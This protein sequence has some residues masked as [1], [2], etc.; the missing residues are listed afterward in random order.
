M[1]QCGVIAAAGIVAM[2]Q[3][4]DRLAE[5]HA[6]ARRLAQ[7]IARVP[8]LSIGTATVETNLVYFDVTASA[9]TAQELAMRLE[10]RGVRVLALGPRRLRAVTHHG[11]ETRDIDQALEALRASMLELRTREEIS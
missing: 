2:E 1:R 7:G 11:I 4:A 5:D 9:L 8:G 10:Q 3:M 6:L